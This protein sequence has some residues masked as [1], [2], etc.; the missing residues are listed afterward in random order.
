VQ[1]NGRNDAWLWDEIMQAAHLQP[2]TMRRV[3]IVAS[4]SWGDSRSTTVRAVEC[5]DSTL[6][7]EY[8]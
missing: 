8:E 5:M 1:T 7:G 2:R 4:R 3:L 6:R